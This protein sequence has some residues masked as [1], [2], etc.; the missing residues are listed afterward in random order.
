MFI[1]EMTG[2]LFYVND[3]LTWVLDR[4]HA[5]MHKIDPSKT[6][7]CLIL[8][9]SIR[10]ELFLQGQGID[11]SH[12]GFWQ[13][14]VALAGISLVCLVLA[15]IQLRRIKRWKWYLCLCVCVSV[16]Q[17]PT[18]IICIT[19]LKICITSPIEVRDNTIYTFVYILFSLHLSTALSNQLTSLYKASSYQ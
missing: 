16:C 3:N 13:N 5:P 15:Y 1:T 17:S 11:Y 19:V 7:I 6:N 9:C 14:Q 2:Q 10:G 18:V 12:W 8:C 4:P